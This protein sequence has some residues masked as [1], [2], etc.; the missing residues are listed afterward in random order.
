M[1]FERDVEVGEFSFPVPSNGIIYLECQSIGS[2]V[3]CQEHDKS[4][5]TTQKIR[6]QKNDQHIL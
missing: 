6:N 1:V 2:I 3:S 4:L 5:H